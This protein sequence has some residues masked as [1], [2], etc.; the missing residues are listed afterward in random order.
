VSETPTSGAVQV[1]S[2]GPIETDK[3]FSVNIRDDTTR[4]L[5]SSTCVA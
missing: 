4:E 2:L 5:V 3:S 1:G